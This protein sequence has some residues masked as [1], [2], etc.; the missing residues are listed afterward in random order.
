MECVLTWVIIVVNIIIIIIIQR[1]QQQQQPFRQ[2]CLTVGDDKTL[3]VWDLNNNN[4]AAVLELPDIARCCCYSPNGHL[5]SAG[6]GGEVTGENRRTP[7]P[8]NGSVLVVSYLQ[9]IIIIVF[10]VVIIVAVLCC[11]LLLLLLLLLLLF[12]CRGY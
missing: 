12:I 10:V 3:R 4:Q 7:R 2:E 11:V 6:I 8:M 9:V 5:I 1:Q